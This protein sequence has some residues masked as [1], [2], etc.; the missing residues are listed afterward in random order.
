[1]RRDL[2]DTASLLDERPIMR[3]LKYESITTHRCCNVNTKA[4]RSVDSHCESWL[5]TPQ[6]ATEHVRN[7]EPEMRFSRI[8]ILRS[9]IRSAG[10]Q[11]A[12]TRACMILWR[13]RVATKGTRKQ[14]WCRE[15]KDFPTIGLFMSYEALFNRLR[16]FP[17]H[18][19]VLK[20]L[21]FGKRQNRQGWMSEQETSERWSHGSISPDSAN[22]V[23]ASTVESRRWPN[24]EGGR[25]SKAVLSPFK[26]SPFRLLFWN[27][28]LHTHAKIRT[29]GSNCN[30]ELCS[31]QKCDILMRR[32]MMSFL[33]ES[34]Q[35]LL[36]Q[37]IC[38]SAL[39]TQLWE[40]LFWTR[41]FTRSEWNKPAWTTSM[42]CV[43]ASLTEHIQG[44]SHH[45]RTKDRLA[46]QSL[47]E[48]SL[49]FDTSRVNSPQTTTLTDQT[50]RLL[51]W[52]VSHNVSNPTMIGTALFSTVQPWKETQ[53]WPVASSPCQNCPG[54]MRTQPLAGQV[55]LRQTAARSCCAL[56]IGCWPG[57]HT[58]HPG[59]GTK[60]NQGWWVGKAITSFHSA[61]TL[62]NAGLVSFL[63]QAIFHILT[64]WILHCQAILFSGGPECLVSLFVMMLF[65]Q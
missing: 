59:P 19:L 63:F 43:M 2:L 41:S 61:L 54:R 22:L 7:C 28:L 18:R 27:T 50:G 49:L 16:F 56:E 12:N 15:S 17:W 24:H 10:S 53:D 45:Q 44:N 31:S 23:V 32:N 21:H 39:A 33:L 47:S 35:M 64:A 9:G 37:L 46:R 57:M 20:N 8:T 34:T 51:P 25:G 4:S 30:G 29:T 65:D 14:T 40:L 60:E 1:M 48:S 36:S 58:K 5:H 11:K 13:F 42:R 38:T 55:E 26:R 6:A 52:N 62:K 3:G